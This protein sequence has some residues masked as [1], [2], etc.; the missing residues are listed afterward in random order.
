MRNHEVITAQNLLNQIL[1]K[2]PFNLVA[3]ENIN[4]ISQVNLLNTEK[5]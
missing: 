3:K 5:V 1:V 4:Y 2:D